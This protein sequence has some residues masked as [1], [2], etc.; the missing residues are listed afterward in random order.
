[1]QLFSVAAVVLVIGKSSTN[2]Q[3]AKIELDTFNR[4]T[5]LPSISIL[6]HIVVAA[7]I[8]DDTV[9]D[10]LGASHWINCST[11]SKVILRLDISYHQCDEAYSRAAQFRVWQKYSACSGFCIP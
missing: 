9:D 6:V 5:V 7:M 10:H 4:E 11:E 2:E 8:K 1:L 3:A